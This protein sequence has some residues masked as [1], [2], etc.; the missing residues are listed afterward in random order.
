[1]PGETFDPRDRAFLADPYPAFA[2]LRAQGPVHWHDAMGLYVTVTHAAA[3][4][5]LRDR[6]L[7][8]IWRDKEPAELFPAFN[9]LHRTSILENEPPTHT[10]LRRLVAGAFGRGHVERL[11][12]WVDDLADR[13]VAR[14]ADEVTDPGAADGADLVALVA[15]PLPVEV[16]AQLLGVPAG[17]RHHL[18]PWSNAIV[19]MYEYGLPEPQ[20]LEAE[21][22]A[23][24]FVEYLRG[25]VAQRRA[26]PVDADLVTDLVQAADGA[27]RLTQDEIVGTCVLLLMAG[28]EAT[29]NVVGNGMLAMLRDPAAWRAVVDDP[30]LVVSAGEEMIRYDSSLQIFER[31]A[32]RRVQ[33]HGTW[34]EE[35]QKIAALLGAANR[36]PAVFAEPD[37]FDVARHPN[38][39]LGFGA[40]IHFCLGAPLARVEVQAVLGALRRRLPGL[41]LAAEPE[42]RPEFVIRGL[43][44]LQ[45]GHEH[46][47]P[48]ALSG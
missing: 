35:G 18:R 10:R 27:D 15:E 6:S 1:M 47:A 26:R 24:A 14:L 2:R 38:P 37:R 12:P 17:D 9:L 30:G 4:T 46:R 31:T 3:D 42:R 7:G 8:R 22:A 16:I 11:R 32:T 45:V 34:V 40:G 20:R 43:R 25:L 23:R 19:K 29:V 39:H 33:V 28:H 5:V 44:G 48:A 21:A 13:L 41:V 36:D